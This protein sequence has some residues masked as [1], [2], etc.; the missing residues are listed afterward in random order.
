[1]PLFSSSL[2][3][4]SNPPPNYV[5]YPKNFIHLALVAVISALNISV[6][7]I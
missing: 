3:Q 4:L 7:I 6:I 2:L 1:M 5:Q